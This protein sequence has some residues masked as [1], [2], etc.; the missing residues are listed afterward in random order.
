MFITKSD[1][2]NNRKFIEDFIREAESTRCSVT[3]SIDQRNAFILDLSKQITKNNYMPLIFV[4]GLVLANYSDIY[5]GV[6]SGSNRRL[7]L[8]QMRRESQL[9][10]LN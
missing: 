6:T 9:T 2:E 1:D 4:L 5:L 7:T 10:R 8:R 3:D